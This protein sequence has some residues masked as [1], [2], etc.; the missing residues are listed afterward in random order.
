MDENAHV[1]FFFPHDLCDI[2]ETNIIDVAK[3]Q[4]FPLFRR[5]FFQCLAGAVKILGD[6][7]TVRRITP[8]LLIHDLKGVVHGLDVP[9]RAIKIDNQV[10]GD[11]EDPGAEL[12]VRF[13]CEKGEFFPDAEKDLGDEIACVMFGDTT[14]GI[15]IEILGKYPVDLFE[16]AFISL[17]GTLNKNKQNGAGIGALTCFVTM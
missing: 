17:L 5:E 14:G 3:N 11:G 4:C 1:A 12:I 15:T 16:G 2:G 10:M 8:E 13:A 6:S 7:K 9:V